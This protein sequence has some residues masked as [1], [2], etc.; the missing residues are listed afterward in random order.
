MTGTASGNADQ[1]RQAFREEA[2]EILADL[3]QALLELAERPRDK[4]LVARVF[5]GLHTIKGSGAMFGFEDVAA[6]TH[7][8]E[9]AFDEVRNERLESSAE[10]IDPTLAALDQIRQMLADGAE[11][12]AAGEQERGAILEKVRKIARRSGAEGTESKKAVASGETTGPRN[13]GPHEN[14]EWFIRFAPGPELLLNGTDPILLL[15]ELRQLGAVS[16]RASPR[17]CPASYGRR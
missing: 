15:R 8:L 12:G 1:F 9:T 4:E 13:T 16:I 17:D 10:L 14:R 3:E 7:E 6:F 2:G 5:R 11:K